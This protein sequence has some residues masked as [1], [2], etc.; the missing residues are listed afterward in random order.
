MWGLGTLQ[1][2]IAGTVVFPAEGAD[3]DAPGD[4][5]LVDRVAQH[6][7][8]CALG[9]ERQRDTFPGGGSGP[10]ERGW[11]PD[12]V[13]GNGPIF[14]DYCK[15]DRCMGFGGGVIANGPGGCIHKQDVV[16]DRV[17]LDL[18]HES[19]G[20]DWSPVGAAD[21]GYAVQ[22]HTDIPF[23]RDQMCA[24]PKRG[25]QDGMIF[26]NLIVSRLT[27]KNKDKVV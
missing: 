10:E 7:T 17:L 26:V 5:A 11:V 18:R 1:V 2:V 21:K 9:D 22:L 8:T 16:A 12:E 19:G 23:L 27:G 14:V 4:F 25:S 3:D 15:G 24:W 13:L 20:G 6:V